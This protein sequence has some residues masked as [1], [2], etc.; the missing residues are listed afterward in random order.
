[1]THRGP[2][3]PLLFCDSVILWLCRTAKKQGRIF[4]LSLVAGARAP[5]CQQLM[6]AGEPA[7]LSASRPGLGLPQ[8]RAGLSPSADIRAKPSEAGLSALAALLL[9]RA[10]CALCWWDGTV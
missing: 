10:L 7:E 6:S 5:L 8:R 1:M 2:C 9:G 3:Q 4:Q